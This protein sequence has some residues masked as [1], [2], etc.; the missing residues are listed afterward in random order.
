[1]TVFF[2]E[3]GAD[4]VLTDTDMQQALHAVYQQLGTRNKVLIVPPDYTRL[5]S[6]AGQLAGFTCSYFGDAVTDVL[7]ALG[8]HAPMS[9]EQIGLMYPA[10]PRH[11]FREHRWRED[12]V[13]IG[14]VD[15]SF[16]EEVT[17]GIWNRPWPCQLNKLIWQGDH[18]LVVSI[19]QVVPH[20]V[21]GMAN[22]NKNLFIGTGGNRGINESHF[23]GA[24]Y[25][26]ERMMGKADTPLRQILNQAE[27][28]FC[29]HLP[30]LYVLTVVGSDDQ[31]N[32]VTRGLFIGDDPECFNR[33]AALSAEVNISWLE[34]PIKRAV[35]YLPPEEFHSTWLGNKAIYRTR[36]AMADDG[37]LIILAPGVSRFGED[38]T[39]DELIRQHGYRTTPEIMAAMSESSAL[40]QNLSAAAHLIHGSTE[41]RFRVTYCPGH[42]TP[43]EIR[44]VGYE[45][46]D[47]AAMS[48]HYR[49]DQLQTGWQSDSDGE[50]YF[51]SNPA[52]GL[53]ACR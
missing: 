47:L 42:L 33:A 3:G 31:G 27:Q 51:I 48:A 26:L 43:E 35:V 28:Q 40:Q 24:A 12:V 32:L 52:L 4:S 37:E 38:S 41:N 8:T 30:F 15:A 9:D 50:Y 6:R 16:V 11:L 18:D 46:G 19:G 17:E 44:Q 5:H 13:T 1:M 36:L 53:W 7:P 14:E 29:Q 39:I 23:I 2:A 10:V 25:G 21:M 22:Y 34:Q 20:E 45:Y 49:P